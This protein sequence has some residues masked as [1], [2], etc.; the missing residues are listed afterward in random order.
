LNSPYRSILRPLLKFIDEVGDFRD[1]DIVT[2]LLPEFVP[3]K[4]WQ[5]LLHN[6]NGLILRGVLSFRPKVV[7]TSVR[8]H[9]S[10]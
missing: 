1:D 5:H 3:A 9:L 7:V 8:R 4:W 6:Q 10:K 2:V